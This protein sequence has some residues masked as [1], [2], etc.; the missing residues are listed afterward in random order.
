MTIQDQCQASY[1]SFLM[2]IISY[3]GLFFFSPESY[4]DPIT[5]ELELDSFHFVNFSSRGISDQGETPFLMIDENNTLIIGSTDAQSSSLKLEVQGEMGAE[6]Y[7]NSDMSECFRPSSISSSQDPWIAVPEGISLP[8]VSLGINAPLDQPDT[9]LS[10]ALEIYS[11]G[12]TAGPNITFDFDSTRS[13]ILA[14]RATTAYLRAHS[15]GRTAT[16]LDGT[17]SGRFNITG[18]RPFEFWVGVPEDV[19]GI[20]PLS[21]LSNRRVGI[22]NDS[23]VTK[24]DISSPVGSTTD[25]F[26]ISS[27]SS[28]NGDIF[29]IKNNGFVGLGN[30]NPMAHFDIDGFVRISIHSSEPMACNES[31]TGTLSINSN[32]QLC[33]CRSDGNWVL[34]ADGE[35]SCVW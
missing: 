21:I 10:Q 11:G 25:R 1:D 33:S 30:Q 34:T 35:T 15:G 29:V 8:N 16:F 5:L 17:S 27:N 19:V 6:Q 13:K 20:A 26:M 18:T 12:T 28:Q 32:Y 24:L 3:V 22:F 2:L 4:A 9:P 14:Y 7:C 31:K 23:S